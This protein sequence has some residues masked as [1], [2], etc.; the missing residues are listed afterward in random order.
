M[1]IQPVRSSLNFDPQAM[2]KKVNTSGDSGTEKSEY[3]KTARNNGQSVDADAG[4]VFAQ[5]ESGRES[6][7]DQFENSAAQTKAASKGARP[8]KPSGPPPGGKTSTKSSESTSST[9]ITYDVQDTNKDGTVSLQEKMQYILK[10][11]EENKQAQ[12]NSQQYNQLGQSSMQSGG[13]LN[14]FSVDA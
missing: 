2:F 4:K 12:S 13:L 6:G 14:T 1:E 11:I 7:T 3:L 5:V 9:T 10:L 8:A